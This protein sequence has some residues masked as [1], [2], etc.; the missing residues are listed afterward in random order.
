MGYASDTKFAGPLDIDPKVLERD[1][2]IREDNDGEV[3]DDFAVRDFA[4]NNK[5][6][7]FAQQSTFFADLKRKLDDLGA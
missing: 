5:S 3:I 6:E 1:A 7:I 2:L 4:K